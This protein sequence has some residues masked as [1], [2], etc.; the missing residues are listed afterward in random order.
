MSTD[1]APNFGPPA[2]TVTAKLTAGFP[3][4]LAQHQ[5]NLQPPSY[6]L[7]ERAACHPFPKLCLAQ[8]GFPVLTCAPSEIGPPT[9]DG[10]SSFACGTPEGDCG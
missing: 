10:N 3:H 8:F 6:S 9:L 7:R 5:Q 2:L 1:S 4:V